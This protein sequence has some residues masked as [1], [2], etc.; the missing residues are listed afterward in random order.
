M[1]P[2]E[3]DWLRV[4]DPSP[5]RAKRWSRRTALG[6]CCC[7]STPRARTVRAF[8]DTLL[9]G[10]VTLIDSRKRRWIC[11]V[12]VPVKR[13]QSLD[14]VHSNGTT[15]RR[16]Q[17][18]VG[19]GRRLCPVFWT[20]SDWARLDRDVDVTNPTALAG[21]DQRD[22]PLEQ[23]VVEARTVRR[24]VSICSSNCPG[25]SGVTSAG[26]SGEGSVTRSQSPSFGDAFDL[27]A[28]DLDTILVFLSRG[29]ANRE[30]KPR[31]KHLASCTALCRICRLVIQS[32]ICCRHQRDD[33][34]EWIGM[35]TQDTPRKTERPL[36]PGASTRSY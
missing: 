14:I 22:P 36:G 23:R 13:A 18:Q 28:H 9:K 3:G 25:L 4:T 11:N 34:T 27:A 30:R 2:D 7:K 17:L 35:Q 26:R 5:E 12:H 24:V 20:N 6:N 32:S 19:V 10:R 21:I 33:A 16:A 1:R 29:V 31:G 8:H 15:K